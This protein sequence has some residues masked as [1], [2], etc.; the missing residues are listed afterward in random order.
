M[1]AYVVKFG[2][3]LWT[4]AMMCSQSMQASRAE[5]RLTYR[6]AKTNDHRLGSSKAIG[7]FASCC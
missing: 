4:D 5:R 1:N 7:S 3:E 2:R 6:Y